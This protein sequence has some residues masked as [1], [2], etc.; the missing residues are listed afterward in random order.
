MAAAV[1][2]T[3]DAVTATA[4]KPA[5]SAAGAVSATA[6]AVTATATKPAVAAAAAALKSDLAVAVTTKSSNRSSS[7]N[8]HDISRIC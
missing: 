5:A 4:T 8:S 1:P 3:A 2:A 6:D 7:R